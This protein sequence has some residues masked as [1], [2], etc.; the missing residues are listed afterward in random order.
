[1]YSFA[2]LRTSRMSKK[3]IGIEIM[4]IWMQAKESFICVNHD[5]PYEL[6][7]VSLSPCGSCSRSTSALRPIHLYTNWEENGVEH[8]DCTFHIQQCAHHQ[9]G[10]EKCLNMTSTEC[11]FV[12]WILNRQMRKRKSEQTFAFKSLLKV[13][14]AEHR[15]LRINSK[16][17]ATIPFFGPE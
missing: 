16:P 8:T 1:M 4:L 10:E 15:M 5:A 12:R 14:A 6:L 13:V 17:N 11:D 3:Q 9:N 2:I 7:L